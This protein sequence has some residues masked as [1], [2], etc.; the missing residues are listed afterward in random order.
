LRAPYKNL[1][2]VKRANSRKV[3][4]QQQEKT[5]LGGSS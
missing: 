3:A 2:T 4:A 5:A 1:P